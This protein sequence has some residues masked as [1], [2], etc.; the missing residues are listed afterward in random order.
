MVSPADDPATF[1]DYD[2]DGYAM[3]VVA[4]ARAMTQNAGNGKGW[5]VGY[6][7]GTIQAIIALAKYE[8]ELQNYLERAVLLAPCFGISGVDQG[9]KSGQGLVGKAE[10]IVDE[11]EK[12]GIYAVN[13]STWDADVARI[14][15]EASE[16]LCE[17]A[18][19]EHTGLHASSLKQA[20]H[21][22]Q[23]NEANR[24]QEYVDNWS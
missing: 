22:L 9:K 4:N 14:C 11:M 5:Y 20:N 10:Y 17:W 3:D 7:A 8:F 16:E 2:L 19:N 18:K 13:S 23:I 12:L 24:F 6:S 1:W 15:G 21:W